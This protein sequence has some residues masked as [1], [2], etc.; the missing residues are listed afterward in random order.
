MAWNVSY[1]PDV[2]Q[3]LQRL[4]SFAAN[5]ILDVIE[6]R[7]RDGEPDKIGKPLRGALAGCRR[8]R[9]GNTRI[10]YRVDSEAIQILIIAV[11]ARR[12]EEVYKL[13]D[14]RV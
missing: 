11:G 5:R 10:V 1:H 7:I 14:R 3:D 8:I 13:A 9:T 12:D 2:Q 4:G 6:D